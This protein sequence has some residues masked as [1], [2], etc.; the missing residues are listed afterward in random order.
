MD[1]PSFKTDN[2]FDMTRNLSAPQMRFKLILNPIRGN[3]PILYS[4][5]FGP[6]RVIEYEGYE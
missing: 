2:L 5:H 3:V 1:Y 4:Y 6:R